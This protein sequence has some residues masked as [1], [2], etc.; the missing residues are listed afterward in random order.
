VVL[1]DEYS[2]REVIVLIRKA[3]E[4]GYPLD[5]DSYLDKLT[6]RQLDELVNQD[7]H[8]A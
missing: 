4:L 7:K 2:L 1:S 6:V 8:D 3:R 5:K